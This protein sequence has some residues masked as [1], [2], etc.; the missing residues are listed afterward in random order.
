M[1]EPMQGFRDMVAHINA[2]LTEALQVSAEIIGRPEE[3][4]AKPVNSKDAPP[5][6]AYLLAELR[7]QLTDVENLA[8]ELRGQMRRIIE[9]I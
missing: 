3:A 1:N 9:R 6:G 7:D 4:T 5:P 2:L 8:L